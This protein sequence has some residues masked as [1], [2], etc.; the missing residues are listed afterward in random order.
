M[1]DEKKRYTIG[2]IA[3][4]YGLG[5]DTIRYYEDKGLLSP[6]RGDNGYRYYEP[7]TIWR[8]N[9]ITDLRGLGFSVEEIGRF[10]ENHRAASTDYMLSEE[11]KVIDSKIQKLEKLR[12]TVIRQRENIRFASS[13][14]KGTPGIKDIPL[15]RAFEIRQNYSSDAA[16]D[17]LMDRLVGTDD[18]GVYIIGNNQ[19]A[20]VLAAGDCGHLYSA[21]W[22]FDEEGDVLVPGGRYLSVFYEDSRKV[23]Q[24]KKLLEDHAATRHIPLEGPYIEVIWIDIHSTSD[25]G[26]YV[27]ELQVRI[28]KEE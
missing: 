9:T 8:M 5:V 17:L 12:S 3:K 21:A 6:V 26:E 13:C 22:L 28:G 24:Y 18:N 15:R 23:L 14:P 25:P 27:Y 20:S 10:L 4:L 1:N 2:E 19:I 11:L 7:S 16:M